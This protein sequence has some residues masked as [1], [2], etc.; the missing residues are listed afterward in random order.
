MLSAL[1]TQLERRVDAL[2]AEIAPLLIEPLSAL[3]RR[4]AEHITFQLQNVWE[5]FV[6]NFILS[7]ATGHAVGAAGKVPASA[8]YSFRSREAVRV[9]LLQ[10]TGNRFE[11]KWYRPVDA[12]RAATR[13]QIHNLTNVTAA[14]GSTPW[15]LEDLRLTRNF[16]AHRSRSSALDLRALNWFSPGDVI[17]VETTLMPFGAGGVRRFDGWCANMKLIARAML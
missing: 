2:E 8:P 13:L 7:S 16:F 5:M 9:L 14:I 6:R 10:R 4:Q 1:V 17:S 12:I 15:P 3:N 11:P